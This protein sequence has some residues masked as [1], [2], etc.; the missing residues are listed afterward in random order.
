[1]GRLYLIRH[2]QSTNNQTWDGTPNHP[3]R[4]SD[5]DITEI[6]H[7]QAQTL[8]RHLAHPEAEPRQIPFASVERADFRLSHVYCSLMTRS[9]VTA[10][11]VAEACG[12]KL[13]ALPDIFEQHGIYHV[14]ERGVC[15]GLPGPGR[16]YFEQRF[17]QLTLPESI[18]GEGWWNRPY[19]EEDAFVERVDRV[20]DEIGRRLAGN[21]E[22]VAMISHGD[23]IDQFV[24][25]LMSVGRHRHNYDNHWV[26]NWT[27]HN[28]SITRIDFVDGAH[29]VVY[30]N[31]LDHLPNPLVTW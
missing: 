7:R 31:R 24:N 5:P 26:A 29:N 11:Y 28:T 19:E 10:G 8:A 23:F 12:L 17:P 9:I 15:E 3:G 4:E 18:D 22:R 6:G 13:E 21:D 25:A 20:V 30:L 14:N 27:F 16:A 1:M 2:A